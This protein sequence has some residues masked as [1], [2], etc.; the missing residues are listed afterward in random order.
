MLWIEIYVVI[1]TK[2]LLKA[3]QIY[4]QEQIQ[5]TR[6]RVQPLRCTNKRVDSCTHHV[7]KTM[8]IRILY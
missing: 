7:L 8:E 3:L 6:A 4:K 5:K 1:C 2:Y